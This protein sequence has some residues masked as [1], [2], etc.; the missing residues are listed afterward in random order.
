MSDVYECRRGGAGRWGMPWARLAEARVRGDYRQAFRRNDGR[1][2]GL[3][4]TLI[5]LLVVIAIIAIL[6]SMLLP[7]LSKAKLKAKRVQCLSNV[8]QLALAA[9]MYQSDSG[10]PID[11]PD[12]NTLW[13]E[14]LM[15]Y[16]ARVQQIRLCPVATLTNGSSMGMGDAAHPWL[17]TGNRGT[18]WTG[19]YAINGWF[20][21]FKG[22]TQ[23]YFPGDAAKCFANDGAVR[24]SSRTPY[25]VDANWPDIWPKATDQPIPN[26]YTGGTAADQEMQRCL[27]ARHGSF[28]PSAAPR[29]ANVKQPI[30]GAIILG[31]VDQHAEL[32]P[33]E[34]LWNWEWHAGYVEPNPRPLRTP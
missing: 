15:N 1:R 25:F 4:F 20:Y 8:K 21:P 28:P 19:S 3:G 26:L 29:S 2:R 27:L 33:L 5:E 24:H 17:W 23:L 13:M 7:A 30:P 14:P 34:K 6:A 16:Q 22:G 31:F 12:V 32:S 9:I 11:Y 18:N 10:K